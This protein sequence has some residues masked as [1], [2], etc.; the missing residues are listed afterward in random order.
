MITSAQS[1]PARAM[2]VR[3]VP[4]EVALRSK[5]DHVR[6]EPDCVRLVRAIWSH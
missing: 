2:P 5:I 4:I 6:L 3:V 1:L